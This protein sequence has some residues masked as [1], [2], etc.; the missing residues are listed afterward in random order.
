MSIPGNISPPPLTADDLW[1]LG[2]GTHDGLSHLLG[3]HLEPDEAG[4]TF[5]VW[6]PAATAV[7]V[8]GD[9]NDWS[10]TAS[11]LTSSDAGI[12][13]G[14][15]VEAVVG[16]SYKYQVRAVGGSVVDKADPVGFATEEPPRTASRIWS[17]DYNWADAD[18]MT[19][20]AA[21][22][23]HDA[24]ISIYEVH[25]GSW[26]YEP[27]GYRALA[28]QLAD[29][30][31]RTGFTHVELLP[32]MEH[33]FYGSWGY[34][35]TGYFA[36]TARYG[37]PQDLMYL[38]DVLHQRG[39]GVLLDW[40]PSHF[41]NDAHGLAVFD[42]THLYEHADPRLGFHPDWK[43]GIFNYDRHE[44]RSFLLSSARFWLERYHADGLRVD[45]VASMLYRDYSRAD[46]EWLPN[47]MG[48]NENL[49]AVTFL[50]ELNRRV[51]LHHPD[52]MTVA[53]ESTAWPGVTRSTD[54]GG[55]GFGFKWDMGWMNDTLGYIGEDPVHRRWHH[56]ELTFRMVYAFDENFVLPLSH[57]EVVHGKGSLLD[58]QPGDEWQK[59]AGLRALFGYQFAIPGKKLL[60][61][62]SELA[63]AGDWNHEQ[64]LPWG[65]LADPAHAGVCS[66]VT[67]LNRIY[68]SERAL[69]ALDNDPTGFQWVIGDD[70][71]NSV[72]GFLRHAP[73]ERS[74]LA[75]ANFTPVPRR[76][77]RVGVPVGGDWIEL[78][79]SDGETF[80]GSG[81]TTGVGIATAEPSHGHDHSLVLT[82]PPLSVCLLAVGESPS[83]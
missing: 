45:A 43:S 16:D 40:V 69:H 4:C 70:A 3:A 34:Q 56:D 42:G 54:H 72:L 1:R 20:R 2:D 35:T 50:E 57:D 64:E 12:W 71:D 60:F 63:M 62:G 41:P 31:D 29:H 32:V 18:W 38:V 58:R 28:H 30:L 46:G 19:N 75:V 66:W 80:G 77:Y 21:H 6:A 33:P 83:V 52:A 22:N 47:E 8:I 51:Y 81:M 36:P 9:F 7:S 26:R 14:H 13:S 78:A 24:P 67:E 49:S 11:P 27:G 74:I 61:M 53:E 55:L 73:G 17:L 76:G 15:V 23:A 39:F 59:L 37:E 68:R 5:R 82:L 10:P 25:L 48:G 44:V 65:L 79:N